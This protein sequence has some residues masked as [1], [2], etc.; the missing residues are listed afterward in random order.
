MTY[1][2]RKDTL[3][4]KQITEI[5]ESL[6]VEPLLELTIIEDN[7]DIHKIKCTASHKIF[8]TNRGWVKATDLTEKDDIKI[9]S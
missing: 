5:S 2:S 1:N 9:I 4:Y 8:T 7:N 3:E 6:P